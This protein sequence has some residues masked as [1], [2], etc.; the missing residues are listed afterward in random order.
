M[1]AE[2]GCESRI[3]GFVSVDLKPFSFETVIQAVDK[4]RERLLRA[5]AALEAA[6]VPYAVVGGNAVA[7]WVARV[8][9][10]AVRNTRDVDVMIRRS[11][12]AAA[13]LALESVGFIYRHVADLDLFLDGPDASPRE[14]VHLV[15]AGERVRPDELASNP[16]VDDSESADA[17]RIISLEALVKIKLT[18]WT[19]KDRVHLR[20]LSE[21]GLIDRTWLSRL[22]PALA[23]RLEALLADPDG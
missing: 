23:A 13:R 5:A 22:P 14:A 15:F 10:G 2:W 20:D 16:D 8:D 21:V 6:N 17:Y 4:V 12:L 3:L 19:D 18:A 1:I 7:A 11:D 9:S